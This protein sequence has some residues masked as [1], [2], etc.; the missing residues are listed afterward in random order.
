MREGDRYEAE[1]IRAV[2]ENGVTSDD[3]SQIL[4]FIRRQGGIDYA[5]S[6]AGKIADEGF[7]ELSDLEDS[8]YFR[9]LSDM[10]RFSMSRAG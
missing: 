3:F 10:T 8:V 1:K 4:D 7:A 5:F 6:R 2:L 9:S